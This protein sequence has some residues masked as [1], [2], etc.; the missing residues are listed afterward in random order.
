[1]SSST[2][3]LAALLLYAIATALALLRLFLEKNGAVASAFHVSMTAALALHTAALISH[4]RAVGRVPLSNQYEALLVLSWFLV[5]SFLAVLVVT[6][7]AVLSFFVTPF[8]LL[9]TA[10]AWF[11]RNEPIPTGLAAIDGRTLFVSHV[12]FSLLGLAGLFIG[13]AFSW[14]YEIQE[15]ALR[16]KDMGRL[17]RLVPSLAVCDRWSQRALTVGFVL[18]TFGILH[19]AL[20]SYRSRGLYIGPS[21]KELGSIVVWVIFA[22]LLQARITWGPRGRRQAILSAAGVAAIAITLFGI[23]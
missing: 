23:A 1:M 19:A 8:V 15:M 13:V 16:N 9:L 3:H 21:A 2:F 18:Y 7:I 5:I 4:G 12:L 17:A 22:A 6:K 20:W 14:M 10:W 11:L